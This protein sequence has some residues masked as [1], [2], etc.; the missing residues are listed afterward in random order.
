MIRDIPALSA[1]DHRT[2]AAHAD[3]LSSALRPK[4]IIEPKGYLVRLFSKYFLF[5]DRPAAIF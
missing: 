3:D 1:Q 5:P 4:M 2:I